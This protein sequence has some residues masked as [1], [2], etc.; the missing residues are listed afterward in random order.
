MAYN[1]AVLYKWVND[2]VDAS[3]EYMDGDAMYK[4]TCYLS[5]WWISLALLHKTWCEFAKIYLLS[6][7]VFITCNCITGR[8]LTIIAS[9]LYEFQTDNDWRS[10]FEG[11]L[12]YVVATSPAFKILEN[13]RGKKSREARARVMNK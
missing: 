13:A 7:I 4:S 11:L 6:I 5:L 12:S 1:I 10:L 2:K 9:M 3:I 8:Y